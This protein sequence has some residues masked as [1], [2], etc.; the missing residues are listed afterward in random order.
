[1]YFLFYAYKNVYNK[2]QCEVALWYSCERVSTDTEEKKLLNKVIFFVFF[3]HKM[4]S[5]SFIKLK[6]NHWCH[7]DYFTDVLTTF[8]GLE[9][10]CCVAVY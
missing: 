7:M 4:Y 1:M 3:T 10:G 2:V 6:L 5:R 9:R 8:L